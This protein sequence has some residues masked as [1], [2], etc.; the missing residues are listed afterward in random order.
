[1]KNTKQFPKTEDEFVKYCTGKNC[2]KC[3]FYNDCEPFNLN[4]DGSRKN[5]FA[6]VDRYQELLKVLRKKKLKKLLS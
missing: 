6:L 1:M 2:A 3:E 5:L 4:A